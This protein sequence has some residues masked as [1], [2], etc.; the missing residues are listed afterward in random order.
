MC[1]DIVDALGI[2]VH[3]RN[4][5]QDRRAD[6][7]ELRERPQVTDVER[8][9]ADDEDEPTFFFEADVGRTHEEIAVERIRDRG[10]TL[11][12]TRNHEHPARDERTR[13]DGRRQIIVAMDDVRERFEIGCRV[14]RFDLDGQTSLTAHNEM[15]FAIGMG[16]ER[17]EGREC[18]GA[19]ARTRDADDD[20]TH[21]AR[22]RA[23]DAGSR[24][25][26]REREEISMFDTLIIAGVDAAGTSSVEDALSRPLLAFVRDVTHYVIERDER[27]ARRILSAPFS[28]VPNVDARALCVAA[29]DRGR[30]V[31]AIERERIPLG[32]AT[33]HAARRF[34]SALDDAQRAFRAQGATA[35]EHLATI[36]IG[37]DFT[38][39][40][41]DRES[42]TFDALGEAAAALDAARPTGVPWEPAA[43]VAA[44]DRLARENVAGIA[45][46]P[47][48]LEP[49]VRREP[50]T[51]RVVK[52][53]RGHFSA[54]SLGAFAECER[55][56]YYRYVCSAVEDR[57]SSA[58]FYGSAFHWALERFHEEFPR[59]D[60]ASADLLTRKLDSYVATA[61][62]RF[63]SG[64]DTTVE[65]ELQRRRAKRTAKRYLAWFLER[66]R[67]APFTVIGIEASVQLDLDG[68]TFIGY[69]DRLDRDDA[70]GAVTV[71]DYKTGNIAESADEY[72]EKVASFRDF[73]LPFYYWAQTALGERVTRLALVPL[74]DASQDVRAVE[75][76]VVPV[77]SPRSY[78]DAPVGTIGINELERAR[79]KMI[80]I[81]AALADGP[82]EA[83]PVTDDPDA[84]GY[85]AYKIACRERPLPRED[86][87]GR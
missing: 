46:R 53:R 52:R 67:R 23:S 70:T 40:L 36:A 38:S 32:T 45:L 56:W 5:R 68:Y 29:G 82:I 43:F 37:F 74:K 31:E 86:R 80:E 71:I 21:H 14:R 78:G 48:E 66:S 55:R 15:H 18:V 64:F 58:S 81:A 49:L 77:S 75:L 59:A 6:F 8:R 3:R 33:A 47:P 19:A 28:S 62:E 22:F 72:R 61:F 12:R 57:G 41:D 87:F 27:A 73:Q 60:L 76:E 26:L 35:N 4:R 84:C 25:V 50:E 69:I 42:R 85:C 9:F 63:R 44:I 54:S 2:R 7:R 39:V 34:A 51:P 1:D 10:R 24:T 79:A 30:V 83:F 17:A 16:A 20:P 11:H 65:Y 13:R